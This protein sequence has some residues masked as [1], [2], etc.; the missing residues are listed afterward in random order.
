MS[1]ALNSRAGRL[2]PDLE[3][4]RQLL[5]GVPVDPERL[6]QAWLA[7]AK[8]VRLVVLDHRACDLFESWPAD[9]E[10]VAAA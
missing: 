5:A 10:D 3:T 9:H 8:A 7:R 2:A 4:Y 1:D 6:D